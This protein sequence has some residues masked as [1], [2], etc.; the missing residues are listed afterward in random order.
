MSRIFD[1]LQRSESERNGEDSE[2]LPAGPELLQRAERHASSNWSDTSAVREFSPVAQ[3]NGD[4]PHSAGIAIAEAPAEVVEVAEPEATPEAERVKL[5]EQVKP[6][7]IALASQ[8]RLVCLTD[9]ESP[10]AEAVRLLGVRLRDLRRLK[11]LKKI[12]IT[13][14][15]P[16]EGKSMIAGNLACTLAHATTERTLLI[17]GDLRRP[18]LAKMFGVRPGTGIC[19]CVRDGGDFMQHIFRLDEAGF[20]IFPAGNA[21]SNPLE[22]LQ[23]PRLPALMDQ[24]AEVFDWIVV[25][26]PPVLPLADTSV[27]M[28]LAD[29]VLLVTRQGTTEKQQLQKGLEALDPKKMLGALLNGAVASAYSGYYYRAADHS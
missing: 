8:S 19:D 1:A 21:P 3:A 9:R 4:A 12:L 22:L 15:I 16:Q 2:N 29:G 13:S 20:W 6:L 10:T 24:L 28:R 5:L 7:E 17:E 23:S 14:T 25:D 27:W 11:P 26:S 18:S